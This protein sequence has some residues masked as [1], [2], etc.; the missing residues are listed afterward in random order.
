MDTLDLQLKQKSEEQKL[1]KIRNQQMEE[2][3]KKIQ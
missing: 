3:H 2:E 1:S